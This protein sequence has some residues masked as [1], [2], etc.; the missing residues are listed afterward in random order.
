MVTSFFFETHHQNG[1]MRGRVKSTA[2]LK[3]VLYG[4]IL[5]ISLI[6]FVQIIQGLRNIYPGLQVK[7]MGIA[8]LVEVNKS[9]DEI[10]NLREL[11]KFGL[12]KDYAQLDFIADNHLVDTLAPL[13]K[14]NT[15]VIQ[16][17]QRIQFKMFTSL[18]GKFKYAMLFNFAAFENKGDPA[19]TLGE[20]AIIRKLGIELIFHCATSCTKGVVEYARNQSNQ[21]STDELVILMHGGGNLL[22]YIFEDFNRKLVLENFP[23]F[24]VILFPQSIWHNATEKKTRFFQDVYSKHQ[25]LTFLYRDRKSYTLG[26]KIFPRVKCYLMPDMAFQIGAKRRFMEPTHDILWLQRTDKESLKYNIPA[27]RQNYDVIISDWRKWKTPHG[28]SRLE[29][30]FLIATNGMLFL[31]RGRV[32]ITDRLHGHILCVLCGIPHVV[33]DPVNNKITSFM[34]SWTAGIE[35]ILVAHSAED[36]LNKATNLLRNLD[37]EIPQAM[38]I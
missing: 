4:A 29:D 6:Y 27:N 15:R 11:Q 17:V 14:T 19:I 22:A 35:N 30:A 21:Y 31:Q 23:D 38:P 1:Q 32:V 20:L 28:T 8:G 33:L 16:E 3:T 2:L 34:K 12:P 9:D 26:K 13:L 18:I 37:N 7:R 5:P 10:N 36:A 25:R 24:E